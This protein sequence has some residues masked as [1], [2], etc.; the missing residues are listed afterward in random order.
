MFIVIGI[1]LLLNVIDVVVH[2]VTDQVEPLRI[3]GN[4]IVIISALGILT[5]PRVRRAWVP[6]AAGLWSLVLNIIHIAQSGIG[7]A[8][9]VFIAGTTVLCLVLAVQLARRPKPLV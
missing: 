3:A 5:L 7:T 8:G 6:I 2:V 1:L 9:M 4:V